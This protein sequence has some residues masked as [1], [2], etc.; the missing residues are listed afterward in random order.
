ML[1]PA[2]REVLL[3]L[4]GVLS[5]CR[6]PQHLTQ[7]VLL[8][9]PQT[10]SSSCFSSF[11]VPAQTQPKTPPSPLALWFP[12]PDPH[13]HPSPGL[14]RKAKKEKVWLPSRRHPGNAFGLASGRSCSSLQRGVWVVTASRHLCAC[15]SSPKR[16]VSWGWLEGHGAHTDHQLHRASPSPVPPIPHLSRPERRV[17]KSVAGVQEAT[18][19]CRLPSRP[20]DR[21]PRVRGRAPPH[22]PPHE[23]RHLWQHTPKPHVTLQ[24]MI[25][26]GNLHRISVFFNQRA[27]LSRP[28]IN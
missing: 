19:R 12:A 24:G 8:P 14:Q 27:A 4:L 23:R 1:C 18:E 28:G 22:L 5:P 11:F 3:H 26:K 25:T 2:H 6:G 7:H 21:A 20:Q 16:W 9:G 17:E 10:S 13:S 15:C